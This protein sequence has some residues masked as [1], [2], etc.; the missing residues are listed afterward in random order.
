MAVSSGTRLGAYEIVN[1]IGA[2]GMGEVYRARDTK[3]NRD[4]AIKVL[5]QLFADDAERLARFTREA[6]TLAALNHPNIAGVH[7]IEESGGVHAL[8]MEFV[9]GADLSEVMAR[10]PIPIADV[11]PIARQIADALEAA[12]DAGIVHRDLKP[13][14]IKVRADGAVKVLDFGLAK[15]GGPG[16][17][18]SSDPSHSPTLTAHATQMGMILGTAAYMAP[19]Q[20]R[21]RPVDRRADIWAYGVIVY[22][23]LTGRRAFEGEE[24]SDVLASVLRQE[25]D[26]TAVPVDTPSAVRRLLRR[27]L[28]KDP[29]KRLSAIGDARLELDEHE[30]AATGQPAA[31]APARLSLVA[32]LWPAVAGIVRTAAIA[33]AFW[34][35][36]QST[37]T[38]NVRRLSILPPL[39]ENLYPDSTAVA[40]SPD[41]TMVAFVV[42]NVS[43][44]RQLWVRSLDSMTA[45]RL[46]DAEGAMMPFWSPD[47]R[48]I[49]FFTG[50]KLKTI[51]A[52][53]GR[54]EVLCDTTNGR[55]ASWNTSNVIIFAPE[56]NGPLY[57]ISASGG[58]PEPIT[59]LDP[60][61]KEFG[62]RFP[63]WLPDGDHFLFAALP[64]KAGK[65]DIFAGSV[66]DGSRTL[67]GSLESAPMYVDP[68]LIL[69]VRQGVLAAQRFDAASRTIQ[70]D[71]V[72]LGDEP[73]SLLEPAWSFTAGRAISAS[74]TGA[75]AYYSSASVNTSATWYDINGRSL[76][77]LD[78]PRGHYES[79]S[80][81]PDGTRAVFVQSTSPS[82]SALW[83]VHLAGGG[84]TPLTRS[85]GRN[86]L[87][88]WSPDSKRVVFAA[89]REGPQN[90]YVKTVDDA[91]PEQPLYRS[92]ALFKMPTD[93]SKD[94]AWI[95]FTQL[96]P[97]TAQN[98]YR[99]PASGQGEP[100]AIVRGRLRDVGGAISPDGRWM[101]YSS[102][103][104]GRMELLVRSFP[105]G[106]RPVQASQQGVASLGAW[107]PDGRQ[108]L[109]LGAD[110]HTLWRVDV[111]PGT[112]LRF[113]TPKQ[114][115]TFP[116]NLLRVAAAPDRQRF[117]VI[118]PER[119]GTGSITVVH[120][121][122]SVLAKAR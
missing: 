42:G 82:E 47:S 27:C 90:F 86:D 116:S 22:E 12:H 62:H 63:S 96:D 111:E 113:G 66:R 1:Q 102:D 103:E 121:W 30:P 72:S 83:L 51:A 23:M 31:Q 3:L 11:L 57:R 117:L 46:D 67:V 9:D 114:I 91:S 70:G 73:T 119:T 118:A 45:R 99:M 75:L 6:Q 60:E 79:A 93:W 10:G 21:G 14:N 101:A 35:R 28:E 33:A 19:E 49:G 68:G 43:Q 2:G 112:E 78:L 81:S 38:E 50:T 25:I 55:G 18:H 26:W 85:A 34:P 53:G 80:I 40:I 24:I 36:A 17:A 88:V 44:S 4:V 87:A 41:G 84:A 56:A 92:D 94:G 64:G 13:A 59:K 97:G 61:R 52:S 109:F 8:V 58:T 104:T 16:G 15:G 89:D 69:Y 100:V 95:T 29:R 110:Q 54:A 7:G 122:P 39:G 120:D 98:V 76:G 20:A 115:A 106:G 71:P 77:T 32:R 108:L 65:F 48:R 74:T 107:T 5:P 37:V 105:D